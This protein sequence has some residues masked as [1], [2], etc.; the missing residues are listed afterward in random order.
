MSIRIIPR[1]DIKGPNLIK[2]INLEGLKVVGNPNDFAIEYYKGGADELIFMDMV[3]SLYNR[4]SLHE[5]IK[6][7]SEKIFIPFTVGGGIRSVDDA[8]KIFDS[9]ADKIAINTAAVKRPNLLKELSDL[10]GSQSVVSYIEAK[11]NKVNSTW[12]ICINNGRENTGIDIMKWIEIVQ[13][14]GIGELLITSVDREGTEKGFADDLYQKLSKNVDVPMIANGGCG[15]IEDIV[16]VSNN[17]SVD[18][19]AISSALHFDKV[20]I[21]E[22]KKCFK[23][24]NFNIRF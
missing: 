4:N 13:K 21:N 14:K 22:I 5:I 3:A 19:V 18:G 17:F 24:K 1:L 16:K 7:A 6:L 11:K 23:R 9:G 10:I 8:L 20:K 12:E 15:K 2:A